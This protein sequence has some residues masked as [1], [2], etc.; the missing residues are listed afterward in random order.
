MVPTYP[1]GLPLLLVPAALV[2][3]WDHAGDLVLIVH[4]LAGIALAFALG[5]AC[6]LSGSW[7][8]VGAAV[9]AASPLYLFTSLQAL[10]DVPAT[11]WADRGRGRGD[12][13]PRRA[14]LG[15]RLRR[16]RLGRVPR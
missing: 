8:L 1:P 7:S 4:S 14:P 15:A 10:S 11:A 3:G 16:L 12:E 13:G 2:A 6:G 9:L 5:R